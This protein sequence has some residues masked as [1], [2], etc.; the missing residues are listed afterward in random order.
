MTDYKLV[1][2]EPTP[3]WVANLRKIRI[4]RMESVIE[5]V[6][7]AAPDVQGEPV[8]WMTHHDEPMFFETARE[9]S[10][11]CDHD[12][13]PIPLYTAPQPAEQQPDITQLVEALEAARERLEKVE[14]RGHGERWT[15]RE[16]WPR[17]FE[18]IDAALASHRKGGD[19]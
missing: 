16:M 9:A 1:P 19:I 18:Q 13:N 11:Y 8:A 12:E 5:D 14:S 7:A 3:E 17:L 2:V 4:D 6:L 15:A 10:A